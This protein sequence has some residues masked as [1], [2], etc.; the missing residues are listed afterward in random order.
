MKKYTTDQILQ[1]AESGEVSMIDANHIVSILENMDI[2]NEEK[3][4]NYCEKTILI[5]KGIF[6]CSDCSL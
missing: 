2:N 1:A 3:Q 4:C 5:N 6:I